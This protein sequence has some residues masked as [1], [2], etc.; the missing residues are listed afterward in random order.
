MPICIHRNQTDKSHPATITAMAITIPT[1]SEDRGPVSVDPLTG[2]TLS[3][4]SAYCRDLK[5]CGDKDYLFLSQAMNINGRDAD[6]LRE[7]KASISISVIVYGSDASA[8]DVG[9]LI[10]SVKANLVAGYIG[11]PAFSV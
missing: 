2:S 11:C 7:F 10:D 5:G 8:T 6:C 9:T 3:K 4:V 1:F